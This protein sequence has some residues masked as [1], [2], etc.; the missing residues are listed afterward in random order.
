MY[1]QHLKNSWLPL[2]GLALLDTVS[3]ITTYEHDNATYMAHKVDIPNEANSAIIMFYGTDAANEQATMA[4]FGRAAGN[5]PLLTLWDGVVDLGA[6]VVTK[7]PITGSILTAL[8]ADTITSVYDEGPYDVT[9]RN[10]AADDTD[11]FLMIDLPGIKDVH[12]QFTT[13][14]SVASIGGILLPTFRY[15]KTA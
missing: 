7:D 5:G 11:A 10:E 6:R 14:T 1:S 15:F 2:H 8:W 3:A 9:L 4:L 13:K 12:L